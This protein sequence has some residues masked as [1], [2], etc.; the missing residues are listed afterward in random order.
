[1][2]IISLMVMHNM[3]VAALATASKASRLHEAYRA[4]D[5]IVRASATYYPTQDDGLE[6]F[7]GALVAALND[8]HPAG[9][10][11]T[12]HFLGL[13][14]HSF[15]VPRAEGQASFPYED[16]FDNQ[17]DAYRA[18][19]T[20]SFLSSAPL[21][22]EH[23]NTVP[24]GLEPGIDPGSVQD[25]SDGNVIAESLIF[26]PRRGPEMDPEDSSSNMTHSGGRH[27]VLFFNFAEAGYWGHMMSN[28]LP[29]VAFAADAARRA[30][31]T[32][33]VLIPEKFVVHGWKSLGQVQEFVEMVFHGKLVVPGKSE[34]QLP[35]ACLGQVEEGAGDPVE[36]CRFFF[37]C[38]L[39]SYHI[40]VRQRMHQLATSAVAAHAERNPRPAWAP[41]PSG[42]PGLFLQRGSD[43]HNSKGD[44][45]SRAL[46]TR[47]KNE[48]A[49][50]DVIENLGSRSLMD[51]AVYVRDHRHLMQVEGS[52]GYHL[53]WLD[54]ASPNG[55]FIPMSF[56]ELVPRTRQDM[57][58][59]LWAKIIGL[60]Y[61]FMLYEKNEADE[62][63]F[64][65]KALSLVGAQ[66]Q[67]LSRQAI[68]L[69]RYD[70]SG[71]STGLGS[72]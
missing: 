61:Y 17:T 55:N 14:A 64:F 56:T 4:R 45:F 39:P 47:L 36:Q 33:W 41:K 7:T 27:L 49:S 8:D 63:R 69:L 29:R 20:L 68:R 40:T 38:G 42:R 52:A 53:I 66:P 48:T 32:L 35:A 25:A 54:P 22:P 58:R 65:S 59:W 31:Y 60:E 67:P 5:A 13:D 70:R 43:S 18:S 57:T 24:C 26:T 1:M 72:G 71:R 3:R 10:N 46:A 6:P 44:A 11:E 21:M 37:S 50:W 34:H 12:G 30:N 62:I 19:R 28:G 2:R 23:Y 15:R 9:K 16:S 51:I